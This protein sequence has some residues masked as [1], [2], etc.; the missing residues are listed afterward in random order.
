MTFHYSPSVVIAVDGNWYIPVSSKTMEG[1]KGVPSNAHV[2]E[3]KLFLSYKERATVPYHFSGK[4]MTGNG[5]EVNLNNIYFVCP[6]EGFFCVKNHEDG[7]CSSSK[8]DKCWFQFDKNW[9]NDEDSTITTV[10]PSSNPP[11]SSKVV[12]SPSRGV[13]KTGSVRI[14]TNTIHSWGT[15][16][17]KEPIEETQVSQPSTSASASIPD[18]SSFINAFDEKELVRLRKENE[19]LK[20]ENQLLKLELQVANFKVANS[21]N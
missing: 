10:A 15:K 2:F 16:K 1:R 21:L 8:G 4:M 7:K 13:V 19:T 14:F 9:I 17:D 6:K 3:G 20:K 12:S 11:L 5:D 18:A